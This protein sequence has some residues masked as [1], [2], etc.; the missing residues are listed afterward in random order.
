[1]N[2]PAV[3]I[4]RNLKLIGHPDLGGAPNAGEGMGV[5]ITPDG[6]R[7]LYIAHENPPMAMSI[8]DVTD[9]SKP[10]L[11][12]QLPVP[13]ADCRANSLIHENETEPGSA[14]LQYAVAATWFSAGLRVYDISDPFR[15]EEIAAFLP[16]AS[17]SATCSWKIAT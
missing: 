15:P 6:R 4:A 7:I 1:M 13:H 12:W 10:T 9:P 2:V 3:R 14:K 5:K 16:D 8:L 11:L 17:G